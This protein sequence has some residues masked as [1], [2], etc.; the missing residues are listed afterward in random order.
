[1]ETNNKDL[2]KKMETEKD[3]A[4]KPFPNAEKPSAAENK[5]GD[6]K[7]KNYMGKDDS[8]VE[9]PNWDKVSKNADGDTSQNAGT[10]K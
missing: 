4:T 6:P 3:D 7:A 1:M 9:G 8:G 2:F 5:G 10:F